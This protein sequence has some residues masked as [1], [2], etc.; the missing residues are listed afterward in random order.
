MQ[1]ET[2]STL[3]L[4]PGG[5]WTETRQHIT[6]LKEQ[7]RIHQA[8]LRRL[9]GQL[10]QSQPHWVVQ[11]NGIQLTNEELGTGG[12]G[13]VKVAVFGGQHVAAKCLSFQLTTSVSLVEKV[14][15]NGCAC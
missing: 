10:P 13:I 8:E 15:D 11:G 14:N 2:I 6:E 1:T 7:L 9:L 5:R 12:W 3:K 4:R